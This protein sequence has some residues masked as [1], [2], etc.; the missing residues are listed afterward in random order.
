MKAEDDRLGY[1]AELREMVTGDVIPA[2]QIVPKISFLCGLSYFACLCAWCPWV[3]KSLDLLEL[4]L[5]VVRCVGSG[6]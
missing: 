6:I 1:R 2:S 3:K 5:Q 4:G